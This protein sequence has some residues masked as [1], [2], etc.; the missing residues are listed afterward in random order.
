MRKLLLLCLL[1][2][3]FT[4]LAAQQG[5]DKNLA[6]VKKV[7]GIEAYILCEPL[8]PYEVVVDAGTGLKAES[9]LTGGLVNKSIAGRVEQFVRNIMKQNAKVDAVI[10]SAGKRIVGVIFTDDGNNKDAGIARVSKM[11]GYPVFVMNEPLVD[12]SVLNNRSGGVKWKSLVTAGVVNNSIEED[13]QEMVKKLQNRAADAMLFEGGK[14][15][16]TIM[17][18]N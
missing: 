2:N 11:M 18:K 7:N 13:V 8:R 14:E 10:Y 3:L 5:A 15:G 9:L 17:F 12:Y 16:M 6:R 1:A 4:Q